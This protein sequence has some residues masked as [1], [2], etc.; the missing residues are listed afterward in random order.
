[1]N[2]HSSLP[3]YSKPVN[4]TDFVRILKASLNVG[5]YRFTRQASLIWLASFPGDLYVSFVLAE[6]RI[7]EEKFAQAILELEKLCELDPEFQE[8]QD[9]LE[10]AKQ[11]IKI[12]NTANNSKNK[13]MAGVRGLQGSSIP[14][15]KMQFYASQKAL[16]DKRYDEAENLAQKAMISNPN[17]AIPAIHHSKVVHSKNDL[18]TYKNVAEL[19]HKR[20]PE[21]IQFE[22]YL[23]DAYLQT[24]DE[25]RAV[26]IL[27]HCVAKDPA[28]QVPARIWGSR[29]PYKTLWPEQMEIMFYLPIPASVSAILGWNQLVSGSLGNNLDGESIHS[30]T[31]SSNSVANHFDADLPG[32][33]VNND[34]LGENVISYSRN[35]SQLNDIAANNHPDSSEL[36]STQ[37]PN[38][39]NENQSEPLKQ[40]QN[41]FDKIAKKI[42][43]PGLNQVD[44]RYPVYVILSTRKGLENQYGAPTASVIDAHMVDLV[45]EIQKKSGW[46]CLLFYPD[47]PSLT[48]VFGI[49]PAL[50]S[51]PWKIK[52]C[53]A[54]LDKALHKKGERIGALLIVGG[55]EVVPFHLLPNPIDDSDPDVPSDNPYSTPDENY[56]VPEWP[57]GR[58][59]GEGG[60]DA[61]LLA[62]Q[63]K[64]LTQ[65]Y[66]C[67]TRPSFSRKPLSYLSW[68]FK[69]TNR[70]LVNRKKNS[71]NKISFGYSAKVWEEASKEVFRSIGQSNAFFTS[72]PLPGRAAFNPKLLSKK[73]GYF[74]LHGIQDGPE[75][76]GQKAI[77]QIDDTPDYPV[78]LSPKDIKNKDL[79]PRVVFSEACYGA[80]IK[81]QKTEESI[82][83]K[84]LASG[85]STFIGS[86]TISYGTVTSPLIGADLLASDFWKE[87]LEGEPAG[88]ALR[89]AKLTLAHEMT[90]RQGYL[91]GEDQK[92]L[93]SFI[94]YG[95]PLEEITE[96]KVGIKGILRPKDHLVLKTVI[97]RKD[98]NLRTDQLPPIMMS[99]VK[100]LMTQYLPGFQDSDIALSLQSCTCKSKNTQ[101]GKC[102]LTA[103][104]PSF[105]NQKRV[106][107]TLSKQITNPNGKFMQFA[108]M[109]LDAHGKVLKISTSR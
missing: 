49:K 84:F 18:L 3:I 10:F 25:S 93:L 81:D 2:N 92:T 59:L 17:S 5:E 73:Y 30:S 91:D 33:L 79:A 87:I 107:V 61:A 104:G 95:D 54:D 23:A 40:I 60:P 89:K 31:N 38:F 65:K 78:A 90:K 43:R 37:K 51:D 6:C 63:L 7:G 16:S 94:L 100:S 19:Y 75:W 77:E 76:Y 21:C 82:A 48:T 41:E 4:R 52:L 26:S 24:G 109:T 70:K 12:R 88:N 71:K 96:K 97:D 106:V 1:M 27:H 44:G 80:L 13:N 64:Q 101:C 29:N 86:T 57:I 22:L 55:P 50:A 68:V 8:A 105:K 67:K 85:T 11:A 108:R 99:E 102:D 46:N 56:F 47:D 45:K 34:S 36:P 15:W 14:A 72:P 53:L 35:N 42:N 20:W 32:F 69:S 28:G 62:D 9:K 103:K 83:L 74:N 98:E 39:E 58:I 66:S